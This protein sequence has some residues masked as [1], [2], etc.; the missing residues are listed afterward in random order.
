MKPFISFLFIT[1][2]LG[3]IFAQTTLIDTDF[4]RYFRT[5]LDLWEKEKYTAAQ[6]QFETYLAFQ[7]QGEL[8]TQ[9]EY[10]ASVCA[11]MLN[12]PDFE[13][14]INAF[15]SKYPTH[16]K[17]KSANYYIGSYYYDKQ[18]Y[19]L[20][21]KYLRG[22]VPVTL[23]TEED[24]AANFKLAYSYLATQQY[25]E[26]RR[27]F[28]RIKRGT[29]AYTESASYYA[30]YLAY[31]DLD[32]TTAIA[33]LERASKNTYYQNDALATLASIFYK[34]GSC[35]KATEYAYRIQTKQLPIAVSEILGECSFLKGNFVEAERHFLAIEKGKNNKLSRP[36]NYRIGFT[37]LKLNKPQ[38]STAYLSL[39]ADGND[40]LA[41]LA[42]YH[43]GIAYIGT[44]EK[45]KAVAA[46]DKARKLSFD[47]KIQENA[48]FY[49][50]KVCYNLGHFNQV[51]EAGEAYKENYPQGEYADEI[52]N[53]LTDAYLNSGDY[54]LAWEK[55]SA[56]KNKNE[57]IKTALQQI[58]FNK[59]SVAYNREAYAEAKVALMQSLEYPKNPKLTE[60]AYYWLGEIY[61]NESNYDSALGW[62]QRIGES[63]EYTLK[64]AY[65]KGYCFFNK[66]EFSK[67]IPFFRRAGALTSNLP[68]HVR[69]DAQLRLADCLLAM[70]NAE[71]AFKS[72]EQ[73]L[74]FV[75]NERDYILLQ[76][77]NALFLQKR[78]DAAL[79]Y[80][81]RLQREYPQ[82]RFVDRSIYSQAMIC[83]EN[84]RFMQSIT[85]LNKIINQFP[86]SPYFMEALNRR[87]LAHQNNGNFEAAS[88]DYK[89]ILDIT[90]TGEYASNAI[91]SLQ[92]IQANGYSVRDFEAYREKYTKANPNSDFVVRSDFELARKPYDD[93]KYY[94]A[95]KSLSD[96]IQK[97]PQS[98][99]AFEAYFY[100][101]NSYENLKNS[102]LAI[103]NYLKVTR[104]SFRFRALRAAAP[105]LYRKGDYTTLVQS[106]EIL[107][108][109]SNVRDIE[110]AQLYLMRG[111]FELKEYDK[112]EEFANRIQNGN[113][114]RQQL[115]ARLFKAKLMYTKGELQN[116]MMMFEPISL[117]SNT[118]EA[119]EAH[120]YI[121]K[122]LREQG[123]LEASTSKL[124]EFNERHQNF[125]KWKLLAFLL[126]A[127]NYIDAEERFQ[128]KATLLS[129]VEHSDN[130]PE[131][132]AQAQRRLEQLN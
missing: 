87:A 129:I 125:F 26:A 57:R 93:N 103:E 44:K 40:T 72:Y 37:K 45:E 47:K 78:Y 49:F 63:S 97:Y 110:T 62:Y 130:F 107:L 29:H 18:D 8:A 39:A 77:A 86:N 36:T 132:K 88:S 52:N 34:Q 101:G 85:Y 22:S 42:A 9:A 84:N 124:Q 128:A 60:G 76:Q 126:I 127:E 64:A 71:E 1:S 99:E 109:S 46:F 118:E 105:M 15:V 74:P 73:V 67:A 11:L 30:G 90:L 59:A 33:D 23:R 106:M 58:A 114:T 82:S 104:G 16:A 121:G 102:E 54:T 17:A 28:D 81:D 89:R 100:I 32:Y 122:I 25:P 10:Y 117:I 69:N 20:A 14:R 79:D 50:V 131:I 21:I 2:F 38:E 119:A 27:L 31:E 80:H 111:Y 19:G 108:S 75:Q 70:G 4:S 113:N 53:M 120:Y 43:L 24:V 68:V 13:K 83:F 56:F 91:R 12:Q 6:Q 51:I 94:E 116:A 48:F 92:E 61:S 55:V 96:F 7:P 98:E 95:I 5:G 66:R 115:T 41:Q 35:E 3:K 123:K 112:C 65:G